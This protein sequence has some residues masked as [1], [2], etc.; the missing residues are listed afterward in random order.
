M[1]HDE[2]YDDFEDEIE[3]TKPTAVETKPKVD[4]L[5]G[6]LTKEETAEAL[7]VSTKTLDRW[8]RLGMGPPRYKLGKTVYYKVSYLQEWQR[9]NQ[10]DQKSAYKDRAQEAQKFLPTNPPR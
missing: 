9:R 6:Y 5:A 10:S 7:R 8:H 4:A 1:S 3:N 2:Q